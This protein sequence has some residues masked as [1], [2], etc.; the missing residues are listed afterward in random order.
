MSAPPA[1]ILSGYRRA[2]Q[3]L[4][5]RLAAATPGDLRRRTNGTKWTNEQLL[6]HMV[7]GYTVVRALLPLVRI[8]SRLPRTGGTRSLSH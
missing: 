4:E 6:F 5:A 1:E 8:I 7:F 2:A 3:E